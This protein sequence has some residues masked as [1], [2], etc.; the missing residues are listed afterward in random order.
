MEDQL[1]SRREAARLLA[2]R[3]QTLA[4]WALDGRHLPIIRIGRTVRYRLADVQQLV[5]H[6]SP[7]PA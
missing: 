2:L 1:I 5:A 4:K 7:A 3:T 6:G